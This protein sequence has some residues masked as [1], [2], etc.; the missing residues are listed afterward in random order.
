VWHKTPL[1]L[2]AVVLAAVFYVV[3]A[4]SSSGVQPFIYFQF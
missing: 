4:M 3:A 2:Q 1:P